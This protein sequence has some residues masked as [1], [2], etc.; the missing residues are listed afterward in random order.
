MSDIEQILQFMVEIE[1]LKNVQ[2]KTRPVGLKRYENSAEHSWH[3][4]LMA[5]MLKDHANE[6]IDINRGNSNA[7]HS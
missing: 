2:R 1:K 5:L 4:S 3:I 7:S 6:N